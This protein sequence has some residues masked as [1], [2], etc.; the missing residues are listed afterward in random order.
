MTK[1]RGFLIE[2]IADMDNLREADRDA[3]DGKVKKN[4]FIRRHN[5][6]AKDDLEALRKMIL[7]L[8]FPDPCLLYTSPSPRD[9]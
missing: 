8:D 3:Q 4:R 7:T 5:E 1:R 9:S 6:R 2:Q